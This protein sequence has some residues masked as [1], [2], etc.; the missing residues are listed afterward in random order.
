MAE[1]LD[2]KKLRDKILENL[3]VKLENFSVNLLL[4]V[5][6]SRVGGIA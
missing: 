5:G 1:I 2:G 4:L 3:R 6:V